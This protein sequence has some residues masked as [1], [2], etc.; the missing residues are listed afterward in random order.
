MQLE[1]L[2]PM[3]RQD[4]GNYLRLTAETISRLFSQLKENKIIAIDRKKI[5]F[6]QLEKLKLIAGGFGIP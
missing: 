4:I 2:L 6:L 1:F 5:H 3:S